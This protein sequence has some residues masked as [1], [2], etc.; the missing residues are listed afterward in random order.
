MR[1]HSRGSSIDEIM[2]SL[3]GLHIAPCP[4]QAWRN[5]GAMLQRQLTSEEKW[6]AAVDCIETA[7]DPKAA[8][9]VRQESNNYYRC[10]TWYHVLRKVSACDSQAVEGGSEG[11]GAYTLPGAAPNDIC[12]P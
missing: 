11:V 6:A 3:S 2:G 9:R 7:G 4:L 12:V 10:A 5:K 1:Q 8:A